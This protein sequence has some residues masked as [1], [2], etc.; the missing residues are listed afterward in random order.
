MATTQELERANDQLRAKLAAVRAKLP[1]AQV[2]NPGDYLTEDQIGE[3]LGM[4]ARAAMKRMGPAKPTQT[5]ALG[6]YVM[7]RAAFEKWLRLSHLGVEGGGF[8]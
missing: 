6:R 5:D 4:T 7:P 3:L 8:L 1:P 2:A